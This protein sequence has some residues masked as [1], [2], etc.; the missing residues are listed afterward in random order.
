[1]K[2]INIKYIVLNELYNNYDEIHLVIFN[3]INNYQIHKVKNINNINKT[4]IIINL[5]E[6]SCI[7]FFGLKNNNLNLI[8]SSTNVVLFKNIDKNII[9]LFKTESNTNKFNNDSSYINEDFI[10]WRNYKIFFNRLVYLYFENVSNQSLEKKILNSNKNYIYFPYSNIIYIPN[11]NL[12]KYYNINL[13]NNVRVDNDSVL[14]IC[15]GHYTLDNNIIKII[16]RYKDEYL[17]MPQSG[18]LYNIIRESNKTTFQFYNEYFIPKS[19]SERDL[20]SVHNGNWT[21][22]GVGVGYGNR[23]N[24]DKTYL[25]EPQIR[26]IL[27][28]DIIVHKKLD[29]KNI[30][31]KTFYYQGDIFSYD[32]SNNLQIDLV[33]KRNFILNNKFNNKFM[34]SYIENNDI[35]GRIL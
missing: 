1:M 23:S 25:I 2:T 32:K 33:I 30:N 31:N 3:N 6:D 9:T 13:I 14:S 15:S 8:A 11:N 27:Y 16:K 19:I 24:Q 20:A 26:T 34:V 17:Y 12:N 35:I 7:K 4:N 5:Y 22:S 10:N 28:F 21:Y 18:Y 29:N